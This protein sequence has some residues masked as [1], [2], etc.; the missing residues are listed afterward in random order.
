[1]KNKTNNTVKQRQYN[2]NRFIIRKNHTHIEMPVFQGDEH[3]G[4][5]KTGPNTSGPNNSG[6]NH[7]SLLF[8]LISTSLGMY[9]NI[10]K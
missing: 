2:F 1:V 3:C 8:I 10:E 4:P 7:P 9:M 5:N 6:P